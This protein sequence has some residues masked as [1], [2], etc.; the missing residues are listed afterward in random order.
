[1]SKPTRLGGDTAR[2]WTIQG[3]VAAEP[4][5]PGQFANEPFFLVHY[6]QAWIWHDDHGFLPTPGKI[7]FKPGVNGVTGRPG[8]RPNPAQSLTG[9][10]QKGGT[11]IRP[12]DLRLGPYRHIVA[13]QPVQSSDGKARHFCT[14]LDDFEIL[15]RNVAIQLDNG[16]AW[17][18]F[19]AYLRDKSGLIAPMSQ[20]AYN[21]LL[22]QEE[23]RL[24]RLR[25]P[26]RPVDP[27]EIPAQKER[28]ARMK[29][30]W[31]AMRAPVSTSL[32]APTPEDL[33]DYKIPSAAAAAP[34]APTASP[35]LNKGR[36]EPS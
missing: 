15:N 22:G 21:L 14:K 34:V 31:E 5:L 7:I 35:K 2:A 30:A 3:D 26:S 20:Y 25:K 17:W 32:G 27:D 18:T 11:I 19:C 8:E 29:A 23:F 10:V 13:S 6:P 4:A 36:K 9:A 1:M 24:R 28:I 12:D 33:S 16:E